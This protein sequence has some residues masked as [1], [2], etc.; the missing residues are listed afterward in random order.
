MGHPAM[1]RVVIERSLGGRRW[2]EDEPPGAEATALAQRFGLPEVVARLLAGRGVPEADVPRFLDP[3]LRDW[4]PDP[5][6]LLDLDRAAARIAD[7][8]ERRS[9]IGVLADYDVDGASSAALVVRWARALDVPT[10]VAIPNRL[11]DGYGPSPALLD[12]L[13]DAGCGLVLVLDAGTTAFAALDHAKRRGLDVVVGA[14]VDGGGDGDGLVGAS[15]GPS[16]SSGPGRDALGAS[17]VDGAGS[18]VTGTTRESAAGE[19]TSPATALADV[20]TGSSGVV[21]KAPT[22]SAT[23]PAAVASVTVV[24]PEGRRTRPH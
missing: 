5:S 19:A 18:D 7:A 21:S 24:N 22:F 17:T 8:V 23:K 14:R 11:T 3:R 1:G 13:A 12:G 9:R 2:V 6:H 10:A 16:A 15:T 20:P 4:L